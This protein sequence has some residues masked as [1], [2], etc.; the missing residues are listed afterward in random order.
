MAEAKAESKVAKID[1]KGVEERE[2]L[3]GSW[4][5]HGAELAERATSAAFGIARDIRGEVNQRVLGTLAWIEASQQG[6]FK[7]LRGIDERIDKLALDAIDAGENISIGVVRA[8]RETGLGVA[9]LTSAF[10]KPAS[11]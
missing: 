6:A 4:V 8:I 3:V 2:G 11:A 1:V 7:L 5:V 9:G 10:G